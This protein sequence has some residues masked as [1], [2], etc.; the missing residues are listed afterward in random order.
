GERVA[1]PAAR[2]APGQDG[3]VALKHQTSSVFVFRRLPGGWRI[4]LIRHPRLRRM[5]IPGGHVEPEES[6]AEAAVREVAEETGLAITLVSPPAAPVP[7][8]YLARRVA[9]PWWIA[10]YQV[11]P[12]NHLDVAHV[13]VDHLYVALADGPA[14]SPERA[15]PEAAAR[16]RG[17]ARPQGE[18]RPRGEA[19]APGTPAHSFGWYAA[20]D[21]AGLDM[22]DDARVLAL[23]LLAALANGADTA[24]ADTA[25]ADTAGADTA[26]AGTAR[27]DAAGAAGGPL[28]GLSQA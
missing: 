21:L 28:A 24:S 4:G 13:H 20:G 14:P 23:S 1:E 26:G 8:G 18:A 10:E 16:P 6:P 25:S 17:E 3:R 2:T 15:R 9:P 22:F 11:P 27:A 19:R 5:M 12:D 7:P